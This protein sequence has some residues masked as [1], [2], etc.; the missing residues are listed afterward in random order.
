MPSSRRSRRRP[1]GAEH[2]PLDPERL[3]GMP[4]SERGP[5]GGSYSVRQVRGSEKSYRCPGCDQLIPPGVAHVVAWQTDHLLGAQ[6]GIDDRRHWHSG[7]WQAR[8]RRRPTR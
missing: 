8:G 6:A 7:C 1:Y 3:R 5:D 2:V 4:R